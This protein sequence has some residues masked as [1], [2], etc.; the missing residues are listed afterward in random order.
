MSSITFFA[1]IL[2]LAATFIVPIY[3]TILRFR[4]PDRLGKNRAAVISLVFFLGGSHLFFQ[5]SYWN[6][7]A[8]QSRITEIYQKMRE[9]EKNSKDNQT[10]QS[11][12]IFAAEIESQIKASEAHITHSSAERIKQIP[13]MMVIFMV[14]YPA[15]LCLSWIVDRLLPRKLATADATPEKTADEDSPSFLAR[16][17][18]II[19]LLVGAVGFVLAVSLTNRG[20]ATN[21]DVDLLILSSITPLVAALLYYLFK[22]APR[23]VD[24]IFA[25]EVLA[26]SLFWCFFPLLAALFHILILPRQ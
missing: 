8:N 25:R 20:W 19:L 10:K 17:C 1:M 3:I 7:K 2:I 24:R 9:T 21:L 13:N 6:T 11:I 22:G 23:G 16:L 5:A 12:A 14:Y 26:P 15:L 4:R 18:M